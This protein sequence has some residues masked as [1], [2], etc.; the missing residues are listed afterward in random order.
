[1]SHIVLL[2]ALKQTYISQWKKKKIVVIVIEV[3]NVQTGLNWIS[4]LISQ[5]EGFWKDF[6]LFL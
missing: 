1:M 4:E 5:N 3:I 2:D 6:K